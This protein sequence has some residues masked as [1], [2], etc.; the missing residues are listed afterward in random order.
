MKPL[1]PSSNTLVLH[2][3]RASSTSSL[4]S[5]PPMGWRALDH[6]RVEILRASVCKNVDKSQPRE[7][8]VIYVLKIYDGASHHLVEQ[9]WA[10]FLELKRD[11][12][13]ALDPGHACNGLCPW[14][15]EDL[16]SNFDIPRR[17]V[18]FFKYLFIR[19][20]VINRRTIQVFREHFQEL[21]DSLLRL[22]HTRG[23]HCKRLLDVCTVLANFLHIRP[24]TI[25][26]A[27]SRSSIP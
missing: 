7:A 2:R 1:S 15:Y 21:L 26:V 10:A 20:H 23:G 25:A 11:L 12:L 3:S 9:S 5:S 18:P 16:A 27:R 19:L 4:T 14:L 17:N 6:V 24:P 22:L 13:T 8:S